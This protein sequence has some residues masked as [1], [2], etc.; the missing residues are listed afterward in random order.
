MKICNRFS[1]CAVVLCVGVLASPLFA[2]SK[3]ERARLDEIARNAAQDFATRR[4]DGDQTRPNPA[5]DTTGTRVELT[6]DDAVM[7][8]LDRNLDIAVERLNPE[9]QDL[10]I[11]RLRN[12]YKPTLTS[13]I[14]Q[15]SRVQ[16][17]TNQLNGGNIV[18]NDTSTYN[19]G[20]VQALPF[21]G[22]NFNVAWNNQKLTTNNLFA[23]FNPTYNSNLV[24]SYTQPLLRGLII[25]TNRQQ[26]R[27]TAP[28]RAIPES[29]LEGTHPAT[30]P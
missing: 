6:L 17:P 11:A 19:A 5:L 20:I 29:P 8:A 2:Q 24:A 22:G 16:P 21:G 27:G 3:E 4:V 15:Q 25:D 26:L 23:N 1:G 10:N 14:F 30:P 28:P 9:V 12:A 7:R 18:S 13:T